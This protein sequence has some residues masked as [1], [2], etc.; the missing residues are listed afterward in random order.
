[1]SKIDLK[2]LSVVHVI[3]SL[4]KGGAETHLKDLCIELVKHKGPKPISCTV[5]TIKG[6]NY[7][8]NDLAQHGIKTIN[9]GASSYL[10]LPWLAIRLL[11]II[12]HLKADIVHAH[13]APSEL[14]VFFA[15][16]FTFNGAF[17][18][19][20]TSRHND[21]AFF[22]I[23]VFARIVELTCTLCAAKVI[24]ISHAVENIFRKG[25]LC[26]LVNLKLSIMVFLNMTR[27]LEG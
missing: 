4:D 6:D 15:R 3:V 1:M 11:K 20:V 25:R 21:E 5:V 17:P 26:H 23:P 14:L 7:W 22:D 2:S 16:L 10:Q 19:I 27:S 18:R 12:C 8:S 13:L 24:C 9:L